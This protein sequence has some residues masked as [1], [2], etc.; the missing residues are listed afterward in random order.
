MVHGYPALLNPGN[1]YP[2]IIQ[3]LP[4]FNAP[5]VEL[6][7]QA[8][9]AKGGTLRFVDVGAATGDTVLLLKQ[10]CPDMIDEFICIE[11]DAEFFKLLSRNMAQFEDVRSVQTVLS[12]EPMQIRS[13]VKH[14]PGTAAAMGDSFI[15]AVPLDDVEEIQALPIDVLKI[16]VDGFDGAVLSGS[17]ATII[18]DNPVVIFEWHPK[19]IIVTG[20][21]PAEAFTVLAECGYKRFLWFDNMGPFSHFSGAATPGSLEK[22]VKYLLDVNHRRDEHF[23]VIA[24][25]NSTIID[26]VALAESAYSRS[27]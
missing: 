4:L 8:F 22:T 15:T 5:L 16:D 20:N 6:V 10:K 14:H 24:L 13:L 2:F 1:I 3:D 7:F 26:D 17:K 21:D 23:D 27:L 25:P 18:S 19:L 11:G 12:R 9:S